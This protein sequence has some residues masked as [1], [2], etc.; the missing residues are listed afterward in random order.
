[1]DKKSIA[2]RIKDSVPICITGVIFILLTASVKTLSVNGNIIWNAGFILKLLAFSIIA[3]TLFGFVINELV[4]FGRKHISLPKE[5]GVKN[6]LPIFFVSFVVFILSFIPYFLAYYPGI[7]AYDSY[8]QIDQIFTG[9]YNE[10]HPLIH[11]LLIKVSLY[12]GQKIFG[13]LNAGVAIYVIIQSIILAAVLSYGVYLIFKSGRKILSIAVLILMALFPFNGLMAV[14]VTKDIP[15]SAYF[16]LVIL[17]SSELLKK[18]NAVGKIINTLLLFI[19][20]LGCGTYRNNG[21]YAL[22]FALVVSAVTALLVLIFSKKKSDKKS[23]NQ[24]G[25]KIEDENQVD[26]NQNDGNRKGKLKDLS[27]KYVYVCATVVIALVLSLVL[28][29]V[30]SKALGAVQGDRREMLSV[31]IQQFARTYVYH[32]GAGVIA[33]DDNT[34]DEAS[35]A[36]INEFLLYDS[37]KLYKSDISDPVKRN[38]NTWVVTN[39]TSEFVKTYLRLL[40]NYP[41]DYINAFLALNAGFIDFTDETHAHVNEAEGTFGLGYVQTRWEENSL[42]EK[43]FYKDTKWNSLFNFLERVTNNNSYLKI[44]VLKYIFM[45]GIYLWIVVFACVFA[46]KR[47]D[48][49]SMFAFSLIAGYYLTMFFGPCVQLRYI[50]PVM[51][52]V[53]FMALFLGNEKTE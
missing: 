48:W 24:N 45:P 52:T 20:V 1:M 46:I 41:G 7:L 36:L 18:R 6:S 11:T 33:T 9:N 27:K 38:T 42:Y 19:G 47:K 31:P 3:G 44:P 34:M 8:I 23:E 30:A 28:T 17:A 51:I 22:A 26:E 13:N 25:E 49:K 12:F 35:K 15:F 5:E 43:G 50:Y 29:T 37:A 2:N 14:S 10:H 4:S 40:K 32:A 16:L 21:K 53:P 39:K